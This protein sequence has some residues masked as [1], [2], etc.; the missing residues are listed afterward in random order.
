MSEKVRRA[1][2]VMTS[3]IQSIERRAPLREVVER[4]ADEGVTGLLVVDRPGKPL[5][6]VSQ[7]D[8]VSFVA[9]LERGLSGAGEFYFHSEPR[10]DPASGGPPSNISSVDD[11]ALRTVTAE[12]VMTPEL[13][14]VP[15]QAALGDVARLMLERRIHR[16]LV[17]REGAIVGIVSTFDLLEAIATPPPGRR[18]PPPRKKTRP[19]R[20]G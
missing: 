15:A 13:I 10:S 8:V 9:G 4:L 5:G 20:T 17:E 1:E 12:E 3:P 2:E 18:R 11:D 16:V 14:K 7:A 19:S 6:V